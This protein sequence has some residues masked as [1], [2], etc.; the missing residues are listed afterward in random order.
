MSADGDAY[1]FDGKERPLQAKRVW[2]RARF[3]PFVI[4][5]PRMVYRSVHGPA[6]KNERGTFAI[7]YAG[8]DRLDMLTQYYRINKARNFGEWRAAM[9]A[10]G[11]P[12]TNFVYADREGNIALFYN[13]MFPDRA[14]GQDWRGILPGDTS[15]ALWTR[16]LPF[17]AVP[18][19]INPASG[20]IMN[21]NNTPYV[22]AGPGDE[23]APSPPEMGVETDMTNRAIR[24]IEL[25]EQP[26]PIDAAR[27]ERIKFDTG[28]SRASYATPWMKALLA[29]DARGDADIAA[30]QKLLAGWDWTA[31]GRGRADALA[32][33]VLRPANRQHYRRLPPPD[34]REE[35]KAATDYLRR[36]FGRLD[37]PLGEMI[38]IRQGKADFP[39]DGGN[40]TLRA[41]TFWD[42]Q[43]D[44][45][46]AI[47]HGD[48]FIMFV[49][50]DRAGQVRSRSIQPFGQATTR[51]D[52]PHHAD[53]AALFRSTGSSRCI[54]TPPSC[55]AMQSDA[56]S[57]GDLEP[58]HSL[59]LRRIRPQ[60]CCG[61]IR[62]FFALDTSQMNRIT[63][64]IGTAAIAFGRARLR[65]DAE[66]RSRRRS[67]QA[68]RYSLRAVHP[69]QRPEG[70]RRHR[71]QG[72]GGRA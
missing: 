21:A 37:P 69:G 31:D 15:A 70:V 20:Y 40:D 8:I 17:S 18:A 60:L 72:A 7:R 23:I 11:V 39:M 19:N 33:L 12:A 29:I 56:T 64:A 57:P 5:V 49:E 10:Q 52:D 26:G 25:M 54:S 66:A 6:L 16:T 45:R 34:A 9:A 53:Q 22:A 30:A 35:L 3:G 62:S 42:E 36:V 68:G 13:A 58:Q 67:R 44:G 46:L 1:R 51:P 32:V 14:R 24:A 41:A 48:S 71:P 38:R 50:W 4:P 55:A 59:A 43:D 63:L 27:L 28:Y 47:R 61:S 65:P 2:L